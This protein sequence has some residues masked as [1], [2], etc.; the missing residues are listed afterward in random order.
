VDATLT[1]ISDFS[2]RLRYEDLTPA[3]VHALKKRLLDTMACALGANEAAPI[4]IARELAV[5]V[6]STE[7]ARLFCT[8]QPTTQEQAAFVNAAMMRYLDLNDATG[9]GGGH[10]SDMFGA[11]IAAA[12]AQHLDGKTFVTASVLAYELFLGLFAAIQIRHRGWDHVVQTIIGAAAAVAKMRKLDRDG[13]A[14]AIALAVTPNMAMEVARRGQLSMWKGCAGP[15]AGRNAIFA[16]D[17]AAA[18]MT[19]P[20]EV[21]EGEN[22][23]MNAAG[24][25]EWPAMP[26]PGAW[27]RVEG[28]QIKVYPCVYP[29]QSPVEAAL[30]IRPQVDVNAIEAIEVRTHWN[31]WYEA[32][33]EPDKWAP[34]TRETADHSIP[35]VVCAALLDGKLDATSF[36]PQRIADAKVRALMQKLTV[37]HDKELDKLPPQAD[38]SRLTVTLKGGVKKTSSVDH[39]KGH[40]KNPPTDRDIEEK[41]ERMNNGLLAP[42]RLDALRELCWHVEDMKDMADLVE[43][44]RA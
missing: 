29:A 27:Y 35:Y 32:G 12:E 34:A 37:V 19:G 18:G 44:T 24:K 26:E 7:P 14:H 6:S 33:S 17:L 30:V 31:S 22:G 21:F 15:N 43:A 2:H 36:T 1:K 39:P 3:A 28:T 40:V 10:P 23:M 8:L 16:A 25:F 5:K 38:P 4:H 41:L 13:I 42:A 11:L 20:L 9:T